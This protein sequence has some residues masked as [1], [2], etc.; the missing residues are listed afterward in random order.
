VV[1]PDKLRIPFDEYH[2]EYVGKTD[3]GRQFMGCL[4]Y[5]TNNVS[6]FYWTEEQKSPHGDNVWKQRANCFAVLH[7]FD[8]DGKH[9]ET[10]V[11]KA[12]GTQES[13]PQ[14]WKIFGSLFAELGNCT[15]CDIFVRPFSVE[16]DGVLHGL[17]YESEV[18]EE[19]ELGEWVMLEPRD[20]MFHPPWD[21]GEYST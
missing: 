20:I 13:T 3:D 2:F 11:Q 18:D 4:T 6:K 16:C 12:D 10:R 14:D 1:A 5:A 21:G 15:H 7:L 9:L 19:G 17:I 8:A